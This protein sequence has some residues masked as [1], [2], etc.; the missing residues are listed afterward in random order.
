VDLFK[1]YLVCFAVGFCFAAASL[2]LG[3]IF[4]GHDGAAGHGAHGGHGG[5]AE[6]SI[7]PGSMPG[8]SMINPTII[9]SF[10]TA[11]GGLGILFSRISFLSSPWVSLPLATIGG[12]LIAAIVFALF[13]KI[14]RATQS[15]SEG[16]V[17]ELVGQRATVL[18][19]IVPGHVGEIAYVQGGTRYT[20]PAR[21][22]EDRTLASGTTVYIVRVTGSEFYVTWV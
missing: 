3:E 4:G 14:F 10:L 12:A 22:D 21:T 13:N 16:C 6:G 1:I 17:R 20:A 15:S 18:T 19:P 7:G 5:H 11:F 2:L 9:A 8:F